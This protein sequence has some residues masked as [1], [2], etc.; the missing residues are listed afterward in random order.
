MMMEEIQFLRQQLE[1]ADREIS[2][3]STALARA[4]GQREW[5]VKLL[6]ER[7]VDVAAMGKIVIGN[8]ARS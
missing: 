3:A 2:L 1:D 5:V 7:G 6:K 4:V 8:D